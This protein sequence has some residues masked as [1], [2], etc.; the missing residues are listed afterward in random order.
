MTY[1]RAI[2]THA[3]CYIFPLNFSC[4]LDYLGIKLG[5]VLFLPSLVHKESWWNRSRMLRFALQERPCVKKKKMPQRDFLFSRV[6]ERPFDGLS[7]TCS[8][9]HWYSFQFDGERWKMWNGGKCVFNFGKRWEVIMAYGGRCEDANWYVET[10][11]V[12]DHLKK[13]N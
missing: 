4:D 6:M 13:Q 11:C 8:K 7:A 9:R 5:I 12:G 1:V 3:G 2:F 10:S